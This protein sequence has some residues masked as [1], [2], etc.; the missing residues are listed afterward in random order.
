MKKIIQ[1]IR[2]QPEQVR[3]HLLHILTVGFAVVLVLL[4]IYSLGSS[5]TNG[6]T[7]AKIDQNLQPFSA[8]KDNMVNGYNDMS[9]PNSNTTPNTPAS[10]AYLQAQENSL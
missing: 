3:M 8:L 2:R 5:L 1:N 4:W 9:Q 10:N 7:Q 6:D